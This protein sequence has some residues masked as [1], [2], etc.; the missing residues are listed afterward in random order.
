MLEGDHS[1]LRGNGFYP[2]KMV[3]VG[4]KM[5]H[6]ENSYRISPEV[7]NLPLRM[8][9]KNSI[10]RNPAGKSDRPFPETGICL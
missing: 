3:T 9:L 8:K 4:L 5:S 1:D 6:P 7:G 10:S 2:G